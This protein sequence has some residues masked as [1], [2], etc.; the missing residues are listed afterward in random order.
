MYSINF[1]IQNKTNFLLVAGQD[2]LQI[3]VVM[4]DIL[5]S[6]IY[7][8]PI[9]EQKPFIEFQLVFVL[10]Q[11]TTYRLTNVNHGILQNLPATLIYCISKIQFNDSYDFLF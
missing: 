2:S 4:Y 11:R 1:Y 5:Y 7:S 8:L 6:L 10:L 9:R 3:I